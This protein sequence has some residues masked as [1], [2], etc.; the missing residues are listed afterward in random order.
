MELEKLISQTYKDRKL[1][2]EKSWKDFKQ[3]ISTNDVEKL[4]SG[5]NKIN[6][7]Y[8]KSLQFQTFD[9]FDEFMLNSNSVIK[10]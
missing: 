8:G 2:Y 3:G 10:L 7:M 1:T 4:I 6:S 9:E 5:L